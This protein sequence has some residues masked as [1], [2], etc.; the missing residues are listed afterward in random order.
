[1]AVISCVCEVL[2]EKSVAIIGCAITNAKIQREFPVCMH[3]PY[4]MD[5]HREEFI[6]KGLLAA[7]TIAAYRR[8]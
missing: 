4:F 8:R 5:V 6:Y 7:Y 3:C 1:M 2:A